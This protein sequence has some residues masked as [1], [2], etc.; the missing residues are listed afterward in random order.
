MSNIGTTTTS[1]QQEAKVVSPGSFPLIFAGYPSIPSFSTQRFSLDMSVSSLFREPWGRNE[2]IPGAIG[3]RG[4]VRVSSD[5]TLYHLLFL[6]P[7]LFSKWQKTFSLTWVSDCLPH[8]LFGEGTWRACL[9]LLR[10]H[11]TSPYPSS[12]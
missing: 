10:S 1:G 8:R 6:L 11:G 2:N 9:A 3:S 7:R 12:R 5:P 4:L